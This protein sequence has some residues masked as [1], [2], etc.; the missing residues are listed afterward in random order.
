[1]IDS[2]N[3]KVLLSFGNKLRYYRINKGYS[4]EKLASVAD[5]HRTYIGMLE[6]AEKNPTLLMMIKLA[7]ALETKVTNL[8]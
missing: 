2:Q 7:D 3:R 4:Q 6:R 1:M 8:L 5:I